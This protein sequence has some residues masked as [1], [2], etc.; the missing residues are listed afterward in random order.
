MSTMKLLLNKVS[1]TVQNK[2]IINR[3]IEIINTNH[4]QD[5]LGLI[6]YEL[7]QYMPIDIEEYIIKYKVLEVFPEKSMF[8]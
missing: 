1:Y 3:N 2:Y 8:K 4:R 5:I 6:K 7:I